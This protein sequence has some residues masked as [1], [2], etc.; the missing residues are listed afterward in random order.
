MSQEKKHK[1]GIRQTDI[2]SVRCSHMRRRRLK[3]RVSLRVMVNVLWKHA[4]GG[5]AD[6]DWDGCFISI[7]MNE[8]EIYV[9]SIW[10]SRQHRDQIPIESEN[11]VSISCFVLVLCC[12]V[13]CCT[14]SDD[15][16]TQPNTTAGKVEGKRFFIYCNSYNAW[17]FM[18]MGNNKKVNFMMYFGKGIL[19]SVF[20]ISLLAVVWRQHISCNATHIFIELQNGIMFL[21]TASQWRTSPSPHSSAY[22]ADGKT[23]NSSSSCSWVLPVWTW[24]H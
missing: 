1:I 20:P 14:V 23:E 9:S 12:V 6:C 7:W 21:L 10:H 24:L 18:I 3:L 11:N 5:G 4:S 8:Y 13:F 15:D 22:H 2:R 16:N 19:I 17:Q